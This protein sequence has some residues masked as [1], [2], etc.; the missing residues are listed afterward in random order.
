MHVNL[1]RRNVRNSIVKALKDGEL[2]IVNFDPKVPHTISGPYDGITC[3]AFS[4]EFNTKHS[5]LA[6]HATL[7]FQG[8]PCNVRVPWHSITHWNISDVY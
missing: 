8:K 3:L 7:L 1:K 4:K 2:V 6:I 5:D